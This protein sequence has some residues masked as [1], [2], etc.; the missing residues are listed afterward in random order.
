MPH[1]WQLIQ[2]H[3]DKPYY[4]ESPAHDVY[5][6]EQCGEEANTLWILRHPDE[7]CPNNGCPW[8]LIIHLGEDMAARTLTAE[9]Y[10]KLAAKTGGNANE[11][12]QVH[13]L[14]ADGNDPES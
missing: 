3:A 5:K 7:V 10:A 1:R 12:K 11:C 4:E 14:L 13:R 6:C 8:R 9:E 2:G